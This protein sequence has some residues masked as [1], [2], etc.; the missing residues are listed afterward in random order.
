MHRTPLGS[1][2]IFYFIFAFALYALFFKSFVRACYRT[3]HAGQL[4]GQVFYSRCS[5]PYNAFFHDRPTALPN[6]SLDVQEWKS[7]RSHIRITSFFSGIHVHHSGIHPQKSDANFY[8]GKDSHTQLPSQSP[9]K[10]GVISVGMLEETT[11]DISNKSRERVHHDHH[12]SI[13]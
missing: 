9:P 4:F 7:I 10:Q 3:D 5:N 8:F 1:E 12:H 13:Y 6:H 2:D 11:P